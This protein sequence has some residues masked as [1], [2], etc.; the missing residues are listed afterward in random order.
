MSRQI[1]YMKRRGFGFTFRI[2][3]P[4]DLRSRIGTSEITKALHTSNKKLAE[5]MVLVFAARAKHLFGELRSYMTTASDS[6]DDKRAV[7]D[8]DKLQK[9]MVNV[10]HRLNIDD[11]TLQHEDELLAQRRLHK[12]ELETTKLKAE[13]EVLRQLLAGNRDLHS[14]SSSATV[15]PLT[16][17]AKSAA[18]MLK[19]VIDSFLSKYQQDKKPA[20]F[21]KHKPVLTML[22]EVIGDKPINELK[23]ADINDFFEL[24]GN[25]PPRWSD[26]CRKRKLNIRELAC[27]DHPETLGP[28]SFDDTYI[29]CVRPFLKAAKKDWQDQ[30]FPLGLTTEGIEYLGD[31]EEGESKQRA[32]YP[33]ELKRLFE[34]EEMKVFAN[35]KEQA[36]RFSF[37]HVNFDAGRI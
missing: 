13:N 24:L 25:L 5:P 27:L 3:V 9:H 37:D 32:L 26:E 21:K 16:E 7:M 12:Q 6:D 36:H 8:F 28:K 14:T 31:R 17:P 29:A 20:M 23:Q 33:L 2:S 1:P 22:I 11:L 19:T 10:K 15:S 30:G 35:D 4:F 34:G 18:P